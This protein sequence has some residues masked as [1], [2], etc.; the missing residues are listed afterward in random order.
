MTETSDPEVV[1]SIHKVLKDTENVSRAEVWTDGHTIAVGRD[2]EDDVCIRFR[3]DQAHEFI[4]AVR[5]VS[6]GGSEVFDPDV[7]SPMENK[8]LFWRRSRGEYIFIGRHEI[9]LKIS[10][11]EAGILYS[12]VQVAKEVRETEYDYEEVAESYVRAL[13]H[14]FFEV[15][16]IDVNGTRGYADVTLK[17]ER[18]RSVF[19]DLIDECKEDE[20]IEWQGHYI[21]TEM[22]GESSSRANVEYNFRLDV[23]AVDNGSGE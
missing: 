7:D 11:H 6:T 16:G 14:D 21:K 23:E 15:K 5:S 3:F 8:F 13:K 22:I 18:A 19:T 10:D 2:I 1:E 12:A 4:D 17:H 9:L 20:H